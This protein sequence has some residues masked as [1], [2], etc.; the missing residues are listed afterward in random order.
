[1]IENVVGVLS[2]LID[3]N[4]KQPVNGNDDLIRL[5]EL[6]NVRSTS[7]TATKLRL[8]PDSYP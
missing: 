2:A 6:R 5:V 4:N 1:M 8:P 7:G 3:D